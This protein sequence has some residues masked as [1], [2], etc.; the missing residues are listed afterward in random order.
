MKKNFL[1]FGTIL[2]LS[3]GL[4]SCGKKCVVCGDC[5]D[6]ITLTDANG[7]DTAILLLCEEDDVA[8]EVGADLVR[9]AYISDTRGIIAALSYDAV[10]LIEAYGCEC[11]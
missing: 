5:P 9:S 8:V 3:I 7:N 10:S 6:E 11:K 4:T 2:L 1:V